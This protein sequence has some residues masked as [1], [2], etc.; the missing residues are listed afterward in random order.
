VKDD[1]T[2]YSFDTASIEH[3]EYPRDLRFSR[4]VEFKEKLADKIKAT[5]ERATS[6]SNYT[7]F[8][9]HFGE[10]TVVKLDKKEVS[11]QEFILQEL[12]AIR[13]AMSRTDQQPAAR[14]TPTAFNTRLNVC[15]K[16]M[17]EPELLDT[18]KIVREHEHVKSAELRDM[19][20]DHSHILIHFKPESEEARV[21]IRSM[22]TRKAR[23]YRI[24]NRGTTVK[25]SQPD[26]SDQA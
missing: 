13:L 2:S 1:K 4:I 19:G 7:T 17:P 26:L 6:D 25:K 23:Q 21:E 3:L 8:L 11:S 9:K 20:E 18:V 12:A 24:K 14:P 5:H 22:L 10:F 16:G 15:L